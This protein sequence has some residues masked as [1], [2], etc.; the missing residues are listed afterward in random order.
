MVSVSVQSTNSNNQK[1]KSIQ[2]CKFTWLGVKR[3]SVSAQYKAARPQ[4]PPWWTCDLMTMTHIM[5]GGSH[6]F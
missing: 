1:K 5:T 4:R 2:I 3:V 6:D